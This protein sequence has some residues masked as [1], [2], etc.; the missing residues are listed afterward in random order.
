MKFAETHSTDGLI[1]SAYQRGRIRV[2]GTSYHNSLIVAPEQV[3]EPWRPERAELIE[4]GDF[5]PV[6]SLEP[7]IV[8]L[9]TGSTQRFP[10][11]AIYA[12]AINAGVGLEVM[13]TG[14]A[15]RTY[16]ILM[17]EG[18]RVVAALIMI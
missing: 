7:E 16:N 14:A 5:S 6:L 11:P 17:S 8:V 2:G 9:G 4:P 3:L 18:R 1:I 13:D 12:S 10:D 15:C